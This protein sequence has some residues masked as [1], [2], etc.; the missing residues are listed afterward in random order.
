M[1]HGSQRR[2]DYS[3]L[4]SLPEDGKRYEIIRGALFVNPAPPTIHQRVSRRLQRQ[5]EDYFHPRKLGEVFNAPTDVILT[6]E[7]VF[8]PDVLVAGN[9][10]HITRR[11]IERPP[12]IVVEILSPS[13]RRVDRGLKASRY[14]ELGVPHYWIVDPDRRRLECRR[15][16]S[17]V[18]EL[19]IEADGDATVTVP[20]WEGLVID[21]AALW[22]P[23]P[24]A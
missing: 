21:L 7:D 23:S 4:E 16:V 5:L 1:V 20:R 19:E 12:L 8:V 22:A 3:Y 10:E 18:Y 9:A 6:L 17:G 14:A 13:T 2:Y 24:L 15:L 11:G